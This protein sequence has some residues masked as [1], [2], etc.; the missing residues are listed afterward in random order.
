MP[1]T[2]LEALERLRIGNKRFVDHVISLEAP[3]MP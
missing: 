3:N 2:A 1:K